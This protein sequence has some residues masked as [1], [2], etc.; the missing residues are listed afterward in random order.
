MASIQVAKM[1]APCSAYNLRSTIWDTSPNI[2]PSKSC[3]AHI[4]F[5]RSIFRPKLNRNSPPVR[6][7]PDFL[8]LNSVANL[9][10]WALV[11]SDKFV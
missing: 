4:P 6:E 7:N 10:V 8:W 3:I 1:L 5:N 2:H 11:F 9:D